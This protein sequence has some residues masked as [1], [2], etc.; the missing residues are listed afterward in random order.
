MTVTLKNLSLFL[1]LSQSLAVPALKS[2]VDPRLAQCLAARARHI[3][4]WGD[5]N[6]CEWDEAQFSAPTGIMREDWITLYEE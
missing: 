1:A 4:T 2:P 5:G 6:M 3:A